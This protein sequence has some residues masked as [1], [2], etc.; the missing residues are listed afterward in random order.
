MSRDVTIIV[1][2]YQEAE[3]L[4]RAAFSRFAASQPQVRFLFVDDG[5]PD[6]TLE[7][8]QDLSM[9]CPGSEV[10]PIRP[11]QGKAEAVRRGVLHALEGHARAV[12]FW[13]ADLATPLDAIPEFVRLLAV[14]PRV[15]ILMGSRV[16][17]LGREIHRDR[18]RHYF[19]RVAATAVS[20]MLGLEVYDTQCGAKL[21][22][23]TSR[24]E[25]I[26]REPFVTKWIFDV[27]L[28]A[29]WLLLASPSEREAVE[30]YI[31]EVPLLQW[32]DVA[33]SKLK[34]F[35]FVKAPAELARIWW[36]YGRKL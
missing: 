36:E 35:D 13:D 34:K 12:G 27:E 25:Q 15:E 7:V 16:R 32:R 5:S 11:N 18:R 22:R 19:G 20:S 28:L 6:H 1:P 8:L 26:F 29:R 9:R 17:M 21:F 31:V 3:R 24:C 10:L 30:S 33:G 2:C 23:A 14:L 4:D